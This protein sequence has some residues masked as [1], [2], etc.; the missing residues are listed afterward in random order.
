MGVNA[1]RRGL[2]AAESEEFGPAE[3]TNHVEM[4]M[5]HAEGVMDLNLGRDDLEA[6]RD[7]LK[8]ALEKNSEVLRGSAELDGAARVYAVVQGK[9]P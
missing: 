6:A 9:C 2:A 7:H 4:A 1:W 3:P 8:K 5:L